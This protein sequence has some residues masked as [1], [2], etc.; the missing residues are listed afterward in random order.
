M[1]AVAQ[2]GEALQWASEGMKGDR[3][4]CMAAV[5]QNG[6]ALEYCSVEPLQHDLKIC[7]F[8]T[9]RNNGMALSVAS[10]ENLGGPRGV[11]GRGCP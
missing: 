8:A 3:E 6:H 4:L 9:V 11:H 7:T 5:A 2:N 10:E 1:A